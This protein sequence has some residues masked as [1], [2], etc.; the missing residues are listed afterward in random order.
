MEYRKA[1]EQTTVDILF[2]DKHVASRFIKVT[3]D[4]GGQPC[5]Y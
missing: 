3:A 1:I 4:N 2:V 5:G